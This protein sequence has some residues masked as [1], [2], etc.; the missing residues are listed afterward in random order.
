MKSSANGYE[1]LNCDEVERDGRTESDQEC[2]ACGSYN[3]VARIITDCNRGDDCP[4]EGH[5]FGAAWDVEEVR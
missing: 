3:T 2:N 5:S 4:S 1:C